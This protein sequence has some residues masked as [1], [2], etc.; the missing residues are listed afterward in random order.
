MYEVQI[1]LFKDIRYYMGFLFV[2][3]VQQYTEVTTQG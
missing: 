2:G 1:Y 3:V